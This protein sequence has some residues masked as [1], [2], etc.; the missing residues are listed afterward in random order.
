MKAVVI[1]R[2]GG[3]EVLDAR[4]V[5]EPKPGL[6]EELVQVEA[7]GVNFADTMAASGGY[8][9]TPNPPLVAGREFCGT[10]VS[11]GERVMGYAQWGAFAEMVAA[12]S[13]LLWP[14]PR[15]WSAEEGAAFPVNF[16]TAYL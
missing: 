16:F 2:L 6:G 10:R 11:N 4:D 15:G 8:P 13:A 5:P 9:G 12:R 14:V 1:S 7:G 3:P